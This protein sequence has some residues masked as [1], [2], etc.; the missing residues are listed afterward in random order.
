MTDSR[1]YEES[2]SQ[3]DIKGESYLEYFRQK[4]PEKYNRLINQQ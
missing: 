3:Y 2:K 4:H 1:D